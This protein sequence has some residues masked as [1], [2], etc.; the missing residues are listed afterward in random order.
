MRFARNY[1]QTAIGS[2][3]LR[4]DTSGVYNVAVGYVSLYNN[5][6]GF[7]NA[8]L[9]TSSLRSN[10]TGNNNKYFLGRCC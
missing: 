9:G 5:L 10:T 3:A 6:S 4:S 8:A 2:G 7:S 1:D